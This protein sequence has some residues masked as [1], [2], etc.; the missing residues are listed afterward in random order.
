VTAKCAGRGIW[1]MVAA[2]IDLLE[3]DVN[4]SAAELTCTRRVRWCASELK[5]AQRGWFRWIHVSIAQVM[6]VFTREPNS[7]VAY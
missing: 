1:L 7:I 4:P 3:W 6:A 2:A 5:A